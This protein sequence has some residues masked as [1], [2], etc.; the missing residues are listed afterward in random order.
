MPDLETTQHKLRATP[1]AGLSGE[2]SPFYRRLLSAGY[3]GYVQGAIGGGTLY[4]LIGLGIGAAVGI[5][6]AIATA[7]TAGMAALWLIPLLGGG[8]GLYGAHMFADIGKTAAIWAEGADTNEKRRNLFDRYYETPSDAEAK[9]I[10]RQLEEQHLPKDTP[11]FHWK[12]ALIGAGIG[13]V[14]AVAT[15]ALLASGAP[16]GLEFLHGPMEFIAET[17]KL[18]F[19]AEGFTLAGQIPQLLGLTGA[20]ASIGGLAGSI[21][22]ID[23]EHIR[24]WLDGASFVVNDQ[25]K[26]QKEL[27]QREQEVQRITEAS[28]RDTPLRDKAANTQLQERPVAPQL[29]RG[30]GYTRPA[31]ISPQV[32]AGLERPANTVRSASVEDRIQLAMS[33]PVV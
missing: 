12:P 14:L 4:G 23:R 1:T 22:G 2:H 15:V 30:P 8:A 7:G 18:H 32:I 11:F 6:L 26:L 20:A 28:L 13:I 5:P 19:G 16:V 17:F 25:S 31:P 10:K 21:I 9:E 33:T 27:D 24:R 29:E 3:K